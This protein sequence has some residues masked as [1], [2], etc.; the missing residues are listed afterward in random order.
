MKHVHVGSYDI[1]ADGMRCIFDRSKRFAAYRKV[2]G[3][4]TIRKT[5]EKNRKTFSLYVS[6]K[7]A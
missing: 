6:F 7:G 3:L 4:Y 5:K 1:Y 2:I